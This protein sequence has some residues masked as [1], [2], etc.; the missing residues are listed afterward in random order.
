MKVKIFFC[1]IMCLLAIQINASDK[2]TA[3]FVVFPIFQIKNSSPHMVYT[4]T[5]INR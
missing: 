3:D 1:L 2:K 4:P 5:F